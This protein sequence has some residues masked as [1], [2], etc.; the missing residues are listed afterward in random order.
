LRHVRSNEA[1][2]PR[3]QHPMHGERSGR[4][5]RAAADRLSTRQEP[6]E[7]KLENEAESDCA[8]DRSVL[9]SARSPR[10]VR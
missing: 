9:V 7:G 2:A 4:K 10:N 3:V 5:V 8:V 1:V 6:R